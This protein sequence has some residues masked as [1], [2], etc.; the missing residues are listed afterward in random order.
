MLRG[1]ALSCVVISK[2]PF[3]PPERP[4]MK[5]RIEYLKE[6]GHEPFTLWQVPETA[7]ALKQGAG[8]LIRDFND[9]GVLAICDPRLTYQELWCYYS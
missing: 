2:L 6:Q 5:A 7:L 8:R 9:R 4:M 1:S 3:A